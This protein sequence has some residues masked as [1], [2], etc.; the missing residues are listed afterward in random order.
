MHYFLTL[1]G[2]FLIFFNALGQS[3][4]EKITTEI[5]RTQLAI[6][7]TANRAVNQKFSPIIKIEQKVDSTESHIVDSLRQ[8]EKILDLSPETS[9]TLKYDLPETDIN[10]KFLSPDAL[11]D[12]I[13][14][15]Q[16]LMEEIKAGEE[17]FQ[18]IHSKINQYSQ[19]KPDSAAVSENVSKEIE[20]VVLNQREI[21]ELKIQEAEANEQQQALLDQKEEIE[22]NANKAKD[23]KSIKQEFRQKL[24]EQLAKSLIDHREIIKTTQNKINKY[25]NNPYYRIGDY[26]KGERKKINNKPFAERVAFGT[27]FQVNSWNP[28]SIDLAP[29]ISYLFLPNLRIGLGATYRFVFSLDSSNLP[30]NENT[31]GYKSFLEW[32][33]F[34]KIFLHAEYELRK[35]KE[36]NPY[37][38]QLSPY[39][40][41]YILAGIGRRFKFSS[42]VKG[43]SSL[44]YNFNYK[45][46]TS[47]ASP[48]IFRMGAEIN[49]G[50][51]NKN[52][53]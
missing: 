17:R 35:E 28:V 13:P 52:S 47:Y 22:S 14:V 3:G 44:L 19:Y 15:D 43:S 7:D 37:T 48:W 2:V 40:E 39:W 46:G 29:Q 4:S 16:E 20:D 5:S 6:Q 41:E 45:N 50:F 51:L 33:G 21:K 18:E 49:T 30:I 23:I 9:E 11:V 24:D 42:L 34:R 31:H 12:E 1:T 8:V 36:K 38:D 25:K 26:Q 27:N 10:S 53:K 32:D